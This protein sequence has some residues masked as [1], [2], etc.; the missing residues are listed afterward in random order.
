[1]PNVIQSVISIRTSLGISSLRWLGFE[2]RIKK[3]MSVVVGPEA[4]FAWGFNY[5]TA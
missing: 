5:A 3:R 2:N 1:M 4:V